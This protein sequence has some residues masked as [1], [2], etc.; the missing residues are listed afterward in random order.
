MHVLEIK[1]AERGR[2][3]YVWEERDKFKDVERIILAT[4]SDENGQILADELSR[5]LNKARCYL[6]DYKGCKDANEL[7]TETDAKTVRE[8]VL[9]AEPVPLHGLN[10]ID[11]YADEF[12]SLY[13][14]GKPRGVSTGIASV[15]ELFTLQTGYLNV[16]TGYPGDGKSAFIDQIVVNVAKTHGWKTCF[17][18]FEKPPTLHSVQLAQCLVG[19]PFFEGQ[20]QRMTQEAVYYTHLTLPT[21]PYV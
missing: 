5:R 20:N 2:F 15:D 18:S 11:H 8:Q 4:D 10:S 3:K 16:V 17:C 13:E 1:W 14:Q 7:L 12:Q 21:T 19:K 6:V 9:N